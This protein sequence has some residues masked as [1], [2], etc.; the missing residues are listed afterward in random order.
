MKKL[1]IMILAIALV[2]IT[3]TLAL[4]IPGESNVTSS[5]TADTY[6]FSATTSSTDVQAGN[7]TTANLETNM[8]TY[9]WAG[10]LGTVSGNLIL[11]DSLNEILFSWNAK[12]QAVYASEAGTIDW[13][14]LAPAGNGDMP[15]Y[16]T[17]GSDEYDET[18]NALETY[19]TGLFDIAGV[20]Y[21]TTQSSGA[22]V[23]KTYS[24]LSGTDLVW[25]GLIVENGDAYDGSTVDYQMIVPED[26]TELNTVLTT[27]NLWV[28][29]V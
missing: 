3:S 26:G 8:S 1:S 27:Y 23:W 21:A 5:S 22:S 15:V 6:E 13:S 9:R 14:A 12:G 29:L 25:A 7:I 18:F 10:L 24:L 4:A 2:V 19:Q 20:N 11:G 17:T 28:E 16:L